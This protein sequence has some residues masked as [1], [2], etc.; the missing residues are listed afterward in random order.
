MTD[1]QTDMPRLGGFEDWSPDDVVADAVATH[2]PV[3]SFCLT[4]GGGDSTVLAHRCRDHY[5]ELV[6][7]DTGTAVPGVRQFVES[8]AGWI[9]KPLRVL[10]AGDAYR[11]M[12]LGGLALRSGDVSPP[13]GF[14]GP[15]NH[16]IAYT[17]LKERQ[18]ERL[19]R[20]VKDGHPR[21][22]KIMLLSGTRRH[23]SQRRMRTQA[24]RYR[25]RGA[26]LWVNPLL[27]WTN[28]QMRAYREQHDLP[29]S[30]VSALLH[31]S[32]ECNCGSFAAPGEREMLA[33]LW[34]AWWEDTIGALEREAQA[35]G[36]AA[37][38]WGERPPAGPI[39]DGRSA[40]QTGELFGPELCSDCVIR[41]AT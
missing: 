21:T 12:V 20:E 3:A 33:S 24:N 15:A 30:D 28:E 16:T 36:L 10:E 38:R 26:Q 14:P 19:I 8:F 40:E 25:C 11:T 1:P 34:P 6:H 18:I 39:Q 7:I 2:Q 23:E 4:S 9:G 29:Q 32:G 41:R 13:L 27:D 37:C 17:R 22:A 31:R 35:R 5:D